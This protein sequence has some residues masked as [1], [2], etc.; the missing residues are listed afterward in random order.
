MLTGQAPFSG[1]SPVAVAMKHVREQA[2]PPSQLAPDV[3]PDLE[4]IVL[5]AMAKDL[6]ARYQSAEELRADLVA[7][8]RGHPIN[9]PAAAT[10]PSHDDVPT[11]AAAAAPVADHVYADHEAW[12]EPPRRW[13]PIIAT[14][15]GLGLLAAVIVFALVAT[16][17]DTKQTVGKKE[18]P[19][20]VGQPISA[21][22]PAV[23]AAGFKVILRYEVSDEPIDQVIK[24]RPE[25]GLLKKKGSSVVL[26]VS[27]RQVTIPD[28]TGQTE[29][30]A[31]AALKKLG[32]GISPVLYPAPNNAPGTVILTKPPAGTKVD[33][34]TI[35]QVVIAKAPQTPIPSVV[36]KDQAAAQQI[37]QAAGFSAFFV[38]IASD[39]V[40][41]GIVVSQSPTAGTPA[42]KGAQVTVQVSLGPQNV[43]ITNYTGQPCGSSANALTAQGF[44]VTI[45]GNSSGTV[46]AQNPSSGMYPHGTQV[47]L[48]CA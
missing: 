3:P 11:I 8:G 41:A 4:R 37:L 27:A 9:A 43:A 21:A 29:D 24:Q 47:S 25:A 15:L 14:L 31:T 2:V 18:V 13:G 33:K 7:F 1:D 34:G 30:Q 48:T 26:V 40:P 19:D 22:Q 38:P 35:I 17:Q 10:V 32:L 45:T 12:D 6:A 5:T 20:V 23:E 16:K 39:T 42:D 28:L 46:V 44:N 36:G